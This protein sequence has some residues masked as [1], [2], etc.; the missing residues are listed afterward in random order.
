MVAQV[1]WEINLSTPKSKN[2]SKNILFDILKQKVIK[3]KV[4]LNEIKMEL[5]ERVNKTP[6]LLPLKNFSSAVL[7]DSI[8]HLYSTIIDAEDKKSAIR[9]TVQT[10]I[11]SHP[12]RRINGRSNTCLV[13]DRN[14]EYHSPGK[15][16]HGISRASAGHLK[17]CLIAGKIRLGAPFSP[18][19]HYDCIRGTAYLSG[20]FWGCHE[21]QSIKNGRPHLNIAPNDHIRE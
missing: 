5:T 9:E 19:F 4:S 2:E 12:P 8:K 15:S 6:I 14:I 1:E 21:A 16:L 7:V 17:E 10:I 18:G 3:T 13:D 11:F 20:M